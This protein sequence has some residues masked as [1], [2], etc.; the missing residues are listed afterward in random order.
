MR[1][2]GV[3]ELKNHTSRV[4]RELGEAGEPIEV[5]VRGR[6]VARLVPAPQQA[7]EERIER[8][9]M[10]LD[11]LA[12]DIADVSPEGASAASIVNEIRR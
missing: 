1:S 8:W 5:T 4:L 2:I 12:R 11:A 6:T 10:E 9:W 3:R 7:D